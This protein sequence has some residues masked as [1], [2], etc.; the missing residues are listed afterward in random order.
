MVPRLELSKN[1][2]GQVL[3]SSSELPPMSKILLFGESSMGTFGE[4]SSFL[5]E[6]GS[7]LGESIMFPGE[8]RTFLEATRNLLGELR[9][10]EGSEVMRRGLLVGVHCDEGFSSSVLLFPF[11]FKALFFHLL[12]STC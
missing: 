5:G 7:F 3:D 4:S 11:S 1:C 9:R 8:S 12:I 6:D 10:S 2:L